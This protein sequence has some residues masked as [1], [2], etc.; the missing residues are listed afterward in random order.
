MNIIENRTFCTKYVFGSFLKSYLCI[1]VNCPF[2]GEII[3]CLQIDPIHNKESKDMKKNILSIGVLAL[4]LTSCFS[5][6]RV[7]VEKDIVKRTQKVSYEMSWARDQ[8]NEPFYSQNLVFLK[9]I[10][11]N[12]K[13]AYTLYDVIKL[14]AESFD[15]KE[16]MYLLIDEEVIPLPV[17]R[18]EKYNTRKVDEKKS[19]VMRSDSTKISV[20]TGYDV[21]EGKTTQLIH[22]LSEEIINKLADAQEVSLR[23]YVGP[24]AI[25]TEIKGRWLRKVKEWIA[26]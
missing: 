9:E 18:H 4:I 5:G 17:E 24:G 15:L 21:V 19:E 26:K 7:Y 11:E 12:Q 13:V 20:V 23:Y 10:D 1:G 16:D 25:N 14:P 2:F 3:R 22:P 6:N 8:R